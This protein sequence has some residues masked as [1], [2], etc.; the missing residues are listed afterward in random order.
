M[1]N[2]HSHSGESTYV[3]KSNDEGWMNSNLG[4]LKVEILTQKANNR[5]KQASIINE[6]KVFSGLYNHG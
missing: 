5:G 2:P 4:K 1:V 6:S 3:M